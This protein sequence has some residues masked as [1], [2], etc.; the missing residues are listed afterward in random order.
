[1]HSRSIHLS[2]IY[3]SMYIIWDEKK[4]YTVQLKPFWNMLTGDTDLPGV[5]GHQWD[6]AN[7]S[8]GRVS[9]RFSEEQ[10]DIELDGH[11]PG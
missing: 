1:M 2:M 7:P 5:A 9:A 11:H 3:P 8:A 10:G 4:H 6:D